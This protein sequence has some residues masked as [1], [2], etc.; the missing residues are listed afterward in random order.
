MTGARRDHHPPPA[1]VERRR[2]GPADQLRRFEDVGHQLASGA[3]PVSRLG[4]GHVD[5]S[6]GSVAVPE[7][8]RG[9]IAMVVR[10]HDVGGSAPGQPVSLLRS[11]PCA[12]ARPKA[13]D[14]DDAGASGDDAAVR[15]GAHGVL[16][17]AERRR[18]D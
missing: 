7:Q 16:A 12:V 4:R 15:E 10:Q 2:V 8:S 18:H 13:L 11:P 14:D 9:V 1:E 6:L 3:Q 5:R 17:A